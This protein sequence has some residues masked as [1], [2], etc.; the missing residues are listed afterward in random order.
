[1]HREERFGVC[2]AEIAPQFRIPFTDEALLRGIFGEL[3]GA[4]PAG[5]N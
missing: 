1:L 3:F 5:V 2:P 4:A